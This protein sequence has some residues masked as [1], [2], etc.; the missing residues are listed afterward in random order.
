LEVVLPQIV[1]LAAG[2]LTAQAGDHLDAIRRSGALRWGADAEGGGPYVYPDPQRPEKLIGFECDLADALAGKLGVKAVMVQN[3]WD[4]LIPAL[5]RGNFDIILNGLELT[6]D[7]QQRIAMSQPYYVYAQQIL[8]RKA[9]EGLRQIEDLQHKRVGVLSYSVAERL[10]EDMGSVD[11]KVYP[12]N[13]ESLSDLKAERVDAVLLDRPIALFYAKDDS[14]LKFSGASFAVGYY[15]IGL[16]KQDATLREAI[17]QAIAHSTVSDL[18]RSARDW[19]P[20]QPFPGRHYGTGPEL[21]RQ[22]GRE[23]PRRHPMHSPRPNRGRARPGH[24]PMANIAPSRSA[25][26]LARRHSAGHQ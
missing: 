5:E 14:A 12:G 10:L 2:L 3:Q 16:L 24:E 21:C 25:T 7:N 11:V 20:A 6:L 8:T 17:N 4:Q 26:G 23:L 13:V 1:L 9:T 18:L 15:G 19:N 22:R